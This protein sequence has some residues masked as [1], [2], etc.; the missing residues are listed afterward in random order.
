MAFSP[1]S[2]GMGIGPVG[3]GAPGTVL[4]R[5]HRWSLE[6]Q[7]NFGGLGIDAFWVKSASRPKINIEETEIN[8]LN[9]KAYIPGKAVWEPIT[10]TFLDSNRGGA[11]QVLS[12]IT[13][14]YDFSRITSKKMNSKVEN[15][16]ATVT[17]KL[18]DG[19]G[20]PMETWT[21]FDAWPNN[22]DFGELDYSNA[23]P[24]DISVQLRYS[25]VKYNSNCGPALVPSSC[26][27]C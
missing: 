14:I 2:Q 6:V 17:L 7:M 22:A 16:T 10:V 1:A 8:F 3:I 13:A 20:S 25:Q 26:R 18:Y 4:K 12:W 19:C 23:E 27:N 24:A 15:Y 5:K 9:D 11:G 21:L